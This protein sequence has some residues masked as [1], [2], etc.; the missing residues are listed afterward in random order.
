MSGLS[1]AISG[2]TPDQLS[3]NRDMVR[4][5]NRL[6][7]EKLADG[8]SRGLRFNPWAN[9]SVKPAG[10]INWV[11]RRAAYRGSQAGR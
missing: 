6:L 3:A 10:F 8:E 2:I 11:I 4:E 5:L 7:E 1:Q 9:S